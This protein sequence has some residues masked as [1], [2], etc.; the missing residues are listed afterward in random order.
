MSTKV[1]TARDRCAVC[2]GNLRRKAITHE[3]WRKA[4]LRLVRNVPAQVCT[5]CGEV[6]LKETT[7]RA[8]DRLLRTGQPVRTLE[9]PVYDF[10]LTDAE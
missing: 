9:T 7:L 5:R 10:A 8:V 1:R 6:W 3:A 2:G 4:H